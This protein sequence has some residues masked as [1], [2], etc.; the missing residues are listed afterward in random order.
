[1]KI[2]EI[3]RAWNQFFFREAP[4]DGICLFRVLLGTVLLSTFLTDLSGYQHFWG[5]YGLIGPQTFEGVFNGNH[6]N[7]F[8]ALKPSFNSLYFVMA[9]HCAALLCFIMGLK[10]RVASFV[11]LLTLTSLNQ[12]NIYILNSADILMRIL[13][14]LMVFAPS[15]NKF[16]LDALLAK[17]KNRPLPEKA[18]LWVHRL[19]QIQIAVVYVSTVIAKSKGETWLD[20]SAVYYAT[21]IDAFTRFPVPFILD[22]IF[23][24]KL[25]TWSAMAIELALGTLIFVDEFR[26]PLIL[27][28]VIFHL[29]IEYMMAIPTFEILM[30]ICLMAMFKIDEYPALI[31]KGKRFP[32]I[33]QNKL[34]KN[35]ELT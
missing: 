20:G 14:M 8:H 10:T 13:M 16:S 5:P 18:P 7:L 29:G 3:S 11:L 21:R 15:G 31:A 28:G 26:K 12:R 24:L 19:I 27:I 25:G 2:S 22:N 23:M 32:L 6:F 9:L 34:F 4:V 1:M 30:I 17:R 35:A 33:I